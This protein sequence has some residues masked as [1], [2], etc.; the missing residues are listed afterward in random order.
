MKPVETW[1]KEDVRLW[2]SDEHRK[3]FALK[4]R[5]YS[6]YN[7]KTM[8]MEDY[9]SHDDKAVLL[10]REIQKLLTGIFINTILRS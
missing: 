6:G 1:S 9:K 10:Y 4:F 2:L 7:L 8:K 3:E 5:K